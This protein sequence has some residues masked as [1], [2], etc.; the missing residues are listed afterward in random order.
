MVD[1]CIQQGTKKHWE[2]KCQ[3]LYTVAIIQ[4]WISQTSQVNGGTSQ[5][6]Y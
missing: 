1:F 5:I 4:R 2:L 6:P 3:I